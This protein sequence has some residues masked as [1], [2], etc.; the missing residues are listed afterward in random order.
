M[1]G[2]CAETLLHL[3]LEI[4][5]EAEFMSSTHEHLQMHTSKLMTMASTR[6]CPPQGPGDA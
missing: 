4:I 1:H 5:Y 2:V 3:A 6:S